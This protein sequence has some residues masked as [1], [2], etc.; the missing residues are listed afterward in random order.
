MEQD[1][2][3]I[4]GILLGSVATGIIGFFNQDRLF[5]HNKEVLSLENKSTEAVKRTLEEMLNHRL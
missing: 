4:I 2:W 1:L 5:K 3:A